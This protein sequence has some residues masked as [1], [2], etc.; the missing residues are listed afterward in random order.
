VLY[1]AALWQNLRVS[2]RN[3][4]GR[5]RYCQVREQS[6][7]KPPAMS[8]MAPRIARLVGGNSFLSVRRE[9]DKIVFDT[10]TSLA[11]Q[12]NEFAKQAEAEEL[13][14]QKRQKP[15]TDNTEKD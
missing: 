12:F 8:G 11:N 9:V 1:A 4:I 15:T 10:R 13:D 14:R 2:Y 7:A 6:R 5:R 3:C